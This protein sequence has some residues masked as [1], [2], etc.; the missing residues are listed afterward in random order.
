MAV[1][2]QVFARVS[3]PSG[4]HIADWHDVRF[5]AF[6]K[7]LNGGLGPCTL[8][9]P[10]PFDRDSIE[11][12]VGNI[13]EIMVSDKDTSEGG[14]QTNGFGARTIYRGYISLVHRF[15]DERAEGVRVN[16]LGFYTLLALD[17]L[18]NGSQTTLYSEP[19][20]GLTTASGDQ[21]AADVGAMVRAVIDRY[22]A[23]H[24]ESPIFCLG[25]N[26]VP[27][28][29]TDATYTFQQKTYR[30]ALNK[31]KDLAP[32]NIHWYVDENGRFTFKPAPTI[33]THEFVF[34]KHFSSVRVETSVETVRNVALVWDGQASGL[35]KHYED[36]HSIAAY[37]RRASAIV[38]FGLADTDA[39][40]E[41]GSRFL[42]ENKD[43]STKATCRIFDNNGDEDRGYDIEA[44][45]PGD[46]C[47]FIGF[48]SELADTFRG[49]MLVTRVRY[50]PESVEIEI[51]L[52]KSGVL[53]VQARQAQE[54]RELGTGG[55][56]VPAS[57]S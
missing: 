4:V 31:L 45:Q 52:V 50:S 33:P 6:V 46:T 7:E 47:T 24:D 39:A 56:G 38:D 23:E 34:G 18:K 43:P 9:L 44:I 11:L 32:S 40:D 10:V 2:K 36:T 53:D 37:G 28:T 35:Y 30:D 3:L 26:D 54:I 22:R 51:E 19:T 27:D 48:S 41:A 49:N 29:G 42:A 20:D 17:I 57:Y 13:V 21:D 5:D 1:R 25:E 12:L 14:A 8:H 16:L 55:L 15:I